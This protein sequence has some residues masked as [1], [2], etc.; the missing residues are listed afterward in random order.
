MHHE[1]KTVDSYMSW[2]LD[3]IEIHNQSSFVETVGTPQ[4]SFSQVV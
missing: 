4:A 3:V 2:K 1:Q